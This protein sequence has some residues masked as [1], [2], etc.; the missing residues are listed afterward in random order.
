MMRLSNAKARAVT[1]ASKV[2]LKAEQA[3]E[4]LW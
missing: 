2:S 4:A 1:T 3:K